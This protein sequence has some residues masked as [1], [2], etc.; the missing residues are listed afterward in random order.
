[1][2][3]THASHIH[4]TSGSSFLLFCFA[5]ALLLHGLIALLDPISYPGMQMRQRTYQS[6]EIKY[7]GTRLT[8]TVAREPAD[9]QRTTHKGLLCSQQPETIS[10]NNTS[11]SAHAGCWGVAGAVCFVFIADIF[12]PW[13]VRPSLWVQSDSFT[14]A[15]GMELNPTKPMQASVFAL[16]E[17]LVLP[18]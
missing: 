12:L 1:M 18:S 8:S 14:H 16:K 17:A 13:L 2:E 3:C 7:K 5:S 4:D 11:R 6:C 10:C 15:N 9:L